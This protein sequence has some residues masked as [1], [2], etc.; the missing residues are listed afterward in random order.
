MGRDSYFLSWLF[1]IT[2]MWRQ[3]LKEGNQRKDRDLYVSEHWRELL[4]T[5]QKQDGV[6]GGGGDKNAVGNNELENLHW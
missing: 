3:S 2:E 6:V 5:Y 1:Y 4:P